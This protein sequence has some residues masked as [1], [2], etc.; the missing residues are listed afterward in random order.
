MRTLMVFL[1]L[2]A[3]GMG[4]S[5]RGKA[6]P[7][8]PGC[9]EESIKVPLLG[10]VSVYRPET[11]R[12]ARG[13][14]LFISGDGGWN[15][16]VVDMA[17]RSGPHAV[18][19]GISMRY[20]Q[21]LTERKPSS[22]W[23]PAGELESIAQ[24]VEKAYNLPRYV[25]P[26]LVGYSSGATVVYGALAQA[27]PDTGAHRAQHGDHDTRGQGQRPAGAEDPLAQAGRRCGC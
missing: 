26:I 21:K 3:S 19:V 15:L 2:V 9:V 22:C 1:M 10:K 27:P 13:V 24:A 18:V 4:A 5:A 20:W 25:K 7:P 11:V 17:R 23:Y 12:N 6:S 16:G 8:C 14:V